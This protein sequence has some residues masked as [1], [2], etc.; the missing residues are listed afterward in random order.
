M[1]RSRSAYPSLFK[2]RGNTLITKRVG[3]QRRV[4][5]ELCSKSGLGTTPGTGRLEAPS[6]FQR[7]ILDGGADFHIEIFLLK[8]VSADKYIIMCIIFSKLLYSKMTKANCSALQ[9]LLPPQ[10]PSPTWLSPGEDTRS[11][12]RLG[13]ASMVL[14]ILQIPE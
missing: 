4:Q 14:R 12:A 8:M 5:T 13:G 3:T 11:E 10:K 9:G 1:R 2:S 7:L 6:D